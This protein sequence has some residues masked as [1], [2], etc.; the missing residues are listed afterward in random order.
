MATAAA[1]TAQTLF[2]R[3]LPWTVS[4]L[5]L[6][7]YFSAFGHV[8]SANVNFDKQNGMSRGYGFV[9]FSL[10]EGKE[11]VLQQKFH[12]LH[13]RAITIEPLKET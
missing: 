10:N 6:K 4:S 13:G 2:V 1:K 11:A 7:E 8:S 3:N 12:T 9:S 5:Q